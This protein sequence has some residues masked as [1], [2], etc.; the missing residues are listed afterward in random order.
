MIGKWHLGQGRRAYTPTYR[1]FDTWVGY[2][3]GDGDYF[4]HTFPTGCDVTFGAHS[5]HNGPCNNT[6][7]EDFFNNSGAALSTVGFADRG[8][9]STEVFGGEAVRLIRAHDAAEPFFL[10]L[11]MQAVHGPWEAPAADVAPFTRRGSARFINDTNRQTY[12]GMLQSLDAAVDNITAALRARTMWHDR[13]L[14]VL[15]SDNGGPGQGGSPPQNT[16]LRGGK[17]TLWEGGV[18]VL[19]LVCSPG[20]PP[21]RRG[22]S[23]D[24]MAHATD[25]MPTYVMWAAGD[26]AGAWP[27]APLPGH[28]ELTGFDGHNLMPAVLSGGTSPRTE[29]VH[30]LI[31]QYNP[32][33][34]PRGPM[35]AAG[36]RYSCEPSSFCGGA[37]RVGD[38]KLLVGYPG[39]DQHYPYPNNTRFNPNTGEIAGKDGGGVAPGCNHSGMP[40]GA[41]FNWGLCADHCLFDVGSGGDVAELHDLAADPRYASVLQMML[42]RFWALSNA[43]G[44][45]VA[46]ADFEAGQCDAATALGVWRPVDF[47]P[48][49]PPA[50][51]CTGAHCR[52]VTKPGRGGCDGKQFDLWN[53]GNFSS[54]ADVEAKCAGISACL[55]WIWKHD[56]PGGTG[57]AWLCSV[58]HYDTSGESGKWVNWT[59]GHRVPA[60]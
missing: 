33:G 15:T 51:A 43:S 49:P 40:F 10:Y 50:P 3:W 47:T 17:A 39:W 42:R 23:W 1:G 44:Q 59:V 13:T 5:C 45:L 9:Y 14:F 21:R 48:T 38:Y 12:A 37:L 54:A 46:D 18:R 25:W 7:A 36:Y 28:A 41:C 24:G 60:G 31:N 2:G 19:G 55:F 29:V 16:P 57:P 26:R 35:A 32:P 56:G 53:G 22:T 8:R 4:N 20:L 58:D 11:A 34:F 6:C 27:P 52:W 30:A